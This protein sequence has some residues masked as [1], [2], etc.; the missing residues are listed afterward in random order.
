MGL[1]LGKA[2]GKLLEIGGKARKSVARNELVTLSTGIR[3]AVRDARRVSL[4]GELQA[5]RRVAVGRRRPRGGAPAPAAA[6]PPPTRH[7]R[8]VG[9]ARWPIKNGNRKYN[10][11]HTRL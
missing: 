6:A 3:V 10:A 5:V 4:D 8:G 2:R 11:G 1:T 7:H 9:C